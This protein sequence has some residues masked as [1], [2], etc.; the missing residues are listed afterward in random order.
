MERIGS[1]RL[2]YHI[3]CIR[4]KQKTIFKSSRFAGMG[5]S[6]WCKAIYFWGSWSTCI[7][8]MPSPQRKY[9]G[10]NLYFC[11]CVCIHQLSKLRGTKKRKKGKKKKKEKLCTRSSC[12]ST[13]KNKRLF[14]YL[15][16]SNLAQIS[17]CARDR[18]SLVGYNQSIVV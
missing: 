6:Y 18:Q 12:P 14:G 9:S 13:L 16:N 4:S 8:C 7:F 17:A 2:V 15:W 5:C 1:S 3:F 11:V 10:N